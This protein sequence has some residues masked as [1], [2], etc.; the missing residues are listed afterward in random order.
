MVDRIVPAT[1]YDDLAMVRELTG[2]RDAAP[3]LHEPFRQWVLEDRFVDGIRP[4]WEDAGVQFVTD[5]EPVEHAKLRMLNG[6]HSVLAYLGYLAGHKTVAAAASD[7]AF[8]LFLRRF[9]RREVMP[10]L[11]APAGLDLEHY[12]KQLLERYQNPA[13]RHLTWQIAMDGSQKLPQRILSSI[14]DCLAK[15]SPFPCLAAVV[16]GWVRFV[17]GWDEAG[18]MIDVRD[19][20]IEQ[21]RS[22]LAKTG[23]DPVAEVRSLASIEAIFGTDLANNATFMTAVTDAYKTLLTEGARGLVQALGSA[24]ATV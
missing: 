5:V 21:I 2:L 1:T 19:P 3:V 11:A 4:R 10:V 20:L 16:A 24:S 23:S 14:R 17:G 12:S 9:W 13:I 18:Q 6:S 15:G 22:R 7:E 8:A